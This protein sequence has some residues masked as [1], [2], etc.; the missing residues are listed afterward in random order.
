MVIPLKIIIITIHNARGVKN[1]NKMKE[2]QLRLLLQISYASEIEGDLNEKINLQ[3]QLLSNEQVKPLI[4]EGYVIERHIL[5]TTDKGKELIKA[6]LITSNFF[7]TQNSIK[8][9]AEEL[10]VK[11]KDKY[12]SLLDN[13]KI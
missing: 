3:N 2:E 1:I 13:L 10:L 4:D 12:N 11:A 9:D 6:L 5:T 8:K 7:E